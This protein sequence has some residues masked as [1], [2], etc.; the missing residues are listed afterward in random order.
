MSMYKFQIKVKNAGI[1]KTIK[2]TFDSRI[3]A[4]RFME[5]LNIPYEKYVIIPII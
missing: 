1:V 3:E 5:W 2:R 4:H